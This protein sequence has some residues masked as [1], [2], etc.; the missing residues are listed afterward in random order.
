[1]ETTGKCQICLE[2]D[3]REPNVGTWRAN[4]YIEEIAGEIE[5]QYICDDCHADLC[6]EI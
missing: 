5:M 2:Q 4:P 6:A 1:M 3:Y